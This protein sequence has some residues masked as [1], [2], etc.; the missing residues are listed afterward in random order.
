M[1]A[2]RRVMSA[3]TMCRTAALDPA[4]MTVMT[5]DVIVRLAAQ[6]V[7]EFEAGACCPWVRITHDRD[8]TSPR[9]R[10]L[11]GQAIERA[12]RA[13]MTWVATCV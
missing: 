2:E 13:R 5:A 3:I 4:E 7:C 11:Q 1:A 6:D 8:P 9:R 10:D 12:R